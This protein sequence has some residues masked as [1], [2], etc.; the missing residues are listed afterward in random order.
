MDVEK[1]LQM[2]LFIY[3][4][5][6]PLN[7]YSKEV[8]KDVIYPIFWASEEGE[9]TGTGFKETAA[10][11]HNKFLLPSSSPVPLPLPDELADK[12]RSGV[13]GVVTMRIVSF[14][15]GISVGGVLAAIGLVVVIY[16][17]L[18]NRSH[19]RGYEVIGDVGHHD[20]T[21]HEYYNEEEEED[22]GTVVDNERR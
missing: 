17:L 13:Y 12:F 14:W 16:V 9:V 6:T 10:F 1:K 5:A 3:D 8:P 4:S 2:N 7:L 21:A 20:T 15:V 18:K 19:L 11:L 22:A